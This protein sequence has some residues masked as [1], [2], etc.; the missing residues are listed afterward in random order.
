MCLLSF[1]CTICKIWLHKFKV[2]VDF[3][4]EANSVSICLQTPLFVG[5]KEVVHHLFYGM[6][7][8]CRYYITECVCA[9]VCVF[10]VR[11]WGLYRFSLG[12]VSSAAAIAIRFVVAEKIFGTI[13]SEK[14]EHY[15][16]H[17]DNDLLLYDHVFLWNS[18][19]KKN[20]N[21]WWSLWWW[22]RV[23]WYGMR[24]VSVSVVL[25]ILILRGY[26][27][28]TQRRQPTFKLKTK[29][30]ST[31]ITNSYNFCNATKRRMNVDG[32]GLGKGELTEQL[33]LSFHF[34]FHSI[35]H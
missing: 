5:M 3:F 4:Q 7:R 21:I 30:N 32:W 10:V 29:L 31:Q 26:A 22:F 33:I 17:N 11:W 15:P 1:I 8:F 34:V 18:H 28:T 2:V 6:H 13:T 24:I 16:Q 9:R 14:S 23:S 20:T 27:A 19:K 12:E 35:F 25:C